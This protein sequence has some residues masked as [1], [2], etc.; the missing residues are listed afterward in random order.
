MLL[1]AAAALSLLGLVGTPTLLTDIARATG[2]GALAAAFAL[3]TLGF[4]VWRRNAGVLKRYP[5]WIAA[6]LPAGL[7]VLG[8]LSFSRPEWSLGGVSLADTGT[9]GDLG[10][11]MTSSLPLVVAWLACGVA[12]VAIAWPSTLKALARYAPVAAASVWDWRIPQRIWSG[13]GAAI[14]FAFPTKPPLDERPQHIPPSWLPAEVEP[15]E[16]FEVEPPVEEAAPSGP[17]RQVELP[18]GWQE[19]DRPPAPLPASSSGWTLPPMDMLSSGPAVEEIA[20]PDNAARAAL[21]VETLAS[22]GVDARVVQFHEGPVVT[23]FDVEPGW[24]IK[25]RQTVE[26]DR[27][28][29]PV[30]DKD[31]RPRMRTEE[32]SRT[33]VRV[34]QITRLQN[35]LALALAA[36]SLRIEAPVPG[37]PS[38]ASRCRTAPRPSSRCAA[39]SRRRPSSAWRPSPSWRCRWARASPASRWSP[40]WRRCPT[41]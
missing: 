19:E 40:T 2:I 7:F 11:F 38:S 32:V 27:D 31:G 15:I 29:K 41:C 18:M 39:S 1:A 20:K 5:R 35:D 9:G 23:Q 34:N 21:I 33:R 17:P 13:V 24:E 26:R 16:R 12:F 36:P 25:Y 10:D 14:A 22:F 4:L 8:C 28:G 3:G 6:T 30:L 37:Q